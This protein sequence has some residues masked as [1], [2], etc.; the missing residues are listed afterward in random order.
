VF[1]LVSATNRDLVAECDAGSFRRDL[2]YRLAAVVV[3]LPPLRERPDDVLGLF[4]HFIGELAGTPAPAVCDEV[5]AFVRERSFPGNVRELRQLAARV[6]LRHV[7]D[8]PIT[9]GDLPEDERP[10]TAS[11]T[12]HAGL[13]DSVRDAV[14]RGLS[15]AEIKEAAASYAYDAALAASAY[16]ATDAARR[17]GVS[18]RAV[19]AHLAKVRDSAM[20]PA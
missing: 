14:A 12:V 6:A 16:S 5:A 1:R 7:G 19:Q 11:R 13:A 9:P 18:N 20:A 4:R 2:Y 17:L 10:R 3:H 8:G 15:L